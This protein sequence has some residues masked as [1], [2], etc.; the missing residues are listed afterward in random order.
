M[1]ACRWGHESIVNKLLEY[2][3][4]LEIE[5]REG[6]TALIHASKWGHDMIF[7][8]LVER[9][10]VLDDKYFLPEWLV[11]AKRNDRY[12]KYMLNNFKP[13]IERIE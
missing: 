13:I 7:H 9:G 11:Q 4:E 8:L 10:A 12:M 6:H 1:E 5:C 2:G 3:A